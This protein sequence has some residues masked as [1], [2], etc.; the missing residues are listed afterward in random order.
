[1][2]GGWSLTT[3]GQVAGLSVSRVSRII[4]QYRARLAAEM[5]EDHNGLG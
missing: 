5:T 1:V 4:S 3:I 2:E